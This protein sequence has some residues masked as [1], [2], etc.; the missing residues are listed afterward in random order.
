MKKPVCPV[1]TT[2]SFDPKPFIKNGSFVRIRIRKGIG[3]EG[4]YKWAMVIGDRIV[5]QNEGWDRLKDV[6]PDENKENSYIVD[7]VYECNF[8]F[9]ALEFRTPVWEFKEK[10]DMPK[11]KTGMFIAVDHSGEDKVSWGLVANDIIVYQNEG[12]DYIDSWDENGH[13]EVSN[14]L[15]VV[16]GC[17]SYQEA[18]N[19]ATDTGFPSEGRVIWKH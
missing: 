15:V 3:K 1:K 11:L 18:R 13:H 8:G 14:V 19:V 4:I 7:R 10:N 5:F 2:Y 16:D 12:F 6:L 9:D 17:K